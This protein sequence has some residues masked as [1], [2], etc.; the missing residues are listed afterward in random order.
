MRQIARGSGPGA[1][2]AQD[3]LRRGA[4]LQSQAFSYGPHWDLDSIDPTRNK[5]KKMTT[6]DILAYAAPLKRDL[7]PLYPTPRIC[8][9]SEAAL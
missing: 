2:Q 7:A 1:Q 5:H 6:I 3:L 9:Q 8:T 4:K